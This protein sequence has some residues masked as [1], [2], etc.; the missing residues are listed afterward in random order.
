MTDI[1]LMAKGLF[2]RYGVEK[3]GKM[4]NWN[5]LNLNRKIVWMNEVLLY[6]D[7]LLKQIETKINSIK[8]QNDISTVYAIGFNNG[9][10]NERVQTL[11]FLE[12]LRTDLKAQLEQYKYENRR[13]I[14][15]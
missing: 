13:K 6:L 7:F 15:E 1:E 12:Y 2:E 9:A 4:P 5:Y 8:I 3:E 11:K 10:W 14:Y